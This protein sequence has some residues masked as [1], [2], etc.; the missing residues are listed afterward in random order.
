MQLFIASLLS[1][2]FLSLFFSGC[3]YEAQ[4]RVNG[5]MWDNPSEPCVECACRD[6]SVQCQRKRCPPSNCKHPVQRDCCMSCDGENLSQ[7]TNHWPQLKSFKNDLFLHVLNCKFLLAGC[8]YNGREY[9]DGTE[10]HDGSDPC[11][12]CHCYGG[13]VTCS[14][15]P[16][17]EK[18]SHPYKPPRQC[19]GECDRMNT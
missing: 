19:C 8:M 9:L 14:R 5:E 1:I 2:I 6:G 16:C 4:Q 17:D 18:C 3:L 10:F 15:I 12:V 7:C 11:V 13:D